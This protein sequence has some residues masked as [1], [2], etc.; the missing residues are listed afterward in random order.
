[1]EDEKQADHDWAPESQD[2]RTFPR[3]LY[4]A[5]TGKAA[6]I[7]GKRAGTMGYTLHQVT[8]SYM[9]H[10][11]NLKKNPTDEW[12]FKNINTLV[13]DECSLVA[14]T[15]FHSLFKMLVKESHLRR[16]VLLGDVRQ[17]PSIEPG[18]FLS[19]M[20]SGLQNLGCAVELRTNHRSESQ[21]IIEN[22]TRIS[23]Q[24]CPVFDTKR[25]FKFHLVEGGSGK[26]FLNEGSIFFLKIYFSLN[27]RL[28]P[29][30]CIFSYKYHKY[31]MDLR[32]TKLSTILFH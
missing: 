8:F 30:L 11:Q 6:N 25:N 21:L 10:C 15:T 1:M 32:I 23:Q 27:L 3:I 14:I 16:I 18:N 9:R 7:L 13:V 26:D 22:A 24:R 17:L 29:T 31:P 2:E 20:F 5:P 28:Q 12:K 19:D 4:T